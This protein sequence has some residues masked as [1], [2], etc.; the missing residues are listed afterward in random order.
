MTSVVEIT[1]VDKVFSLRGG[2]VET[3]PLS[4]QVRFDVADPSIAKMASGT[5]A[6]DRFITASR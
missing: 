4:V 3:E 1:V 2:N 6:A 5:S